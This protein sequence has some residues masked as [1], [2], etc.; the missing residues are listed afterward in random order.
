MHRMAVKLLACHEL[1]GHAALRCSGMQTAIMLGR[2]RLTSCSQA[3]GVCHPL[4]ISCVC[5]HK[6]LLRPWARA[7]DM[8]LQLSTWCH[9]VQGSCIQIMAVPPAAYKGAAAATPGRPF[10]PMLFVHMA[11]DGAT[12][13]VAAQDVAALTAEV[14]QSCTHLVETASISFCLPN[15]L[16]V[17]QVTTYQIGFTGLDHMQYFMRKFHS[18]FSKEPYH[19]DNH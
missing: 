16:I 14:R 4:Q 10:P 12:A 2:A 6:R 11:R 5:M 3:C 1:P 7:D 15:C 18:K 17:N 13:V 8:M 19:N 9:V